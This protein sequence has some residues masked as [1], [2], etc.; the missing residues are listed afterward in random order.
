MLEMS[1]AYL[2]MD[3]PF[4]VP[5]TCDQAYP[6]IR[7]AKVMMGFPD[8]LFGPNDAFAR[9]DNALAQHKSDVVVGLYPVKNQRQ[10][11]KCDMV[12][13][14]RQTMRI[15]KVFV[16][17]QKT[18]LKYSWIFAVWTPAFTELMHAYLK[19]NANDYI[20]GLNKNEI[21]LGHIVQHAID[22]GLNVIGHA[23]EDQTFI[24]IG[25]PDELI[26]AY[27]KYANCEGC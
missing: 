22:E 26:E 3:L 14:D 23:F 25:T 20:E 1:F 2:L 18:D 8:I 19:R 24:D 9:A 27:K 17:P 5:F 4:G 15:K 6:F 7:D 10:S 16:K 21:Y 11:S 13:W 12:Q